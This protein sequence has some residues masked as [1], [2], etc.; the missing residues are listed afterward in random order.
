MG[1]HFSDL[2][3]RPKLFQEEDGI[4]F[5]RPN[6]PTKAFPPVVYSWSMNPFGLSSPSSFYK[7]RLGIG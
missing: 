6:R 2:I 4:A 3:H 7:I 5:L 1:S